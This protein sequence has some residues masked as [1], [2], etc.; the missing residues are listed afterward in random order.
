MRSGKTIFFF[1]CLFS[2][3]ITLSAQDVA[4]SDSLPAPKRNVPARAWA[5]GVSSAALYTGS[6]VMLNEYWYKGYPRRSFHTMNDFG[7]WL[8]MDKFGHV[9]SAYTFARFSREIWRWSELP[10][11]QQVLI[12]AFSGLAFQSVIEFLDAHS[13]EWGWSWGDMGANALGAGIMAA[14][15]LAWNEQRIQLKFSSTPIHYRD[16]VL[17]ARAT[18]IFGTAFAER[19]LKDYNAQTYWLSLNLRSVLRD[20]RLPRWLNIAAGYGVQGLYDARSNVWND[21]AGS[22]MDFTRI[23]RTRQ[24]YLSPDVDLTRIPTRKKGVK[25]MLQVLNMIKIPAP[26]L[27]INGAGQLKVHGLMF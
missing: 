23:R 4:P 7:E 9:Y 12:G 16:P 24:F 14:Q 27:E 8:Q 15:E 3:C 26:T 2:A 1:S 25:V 18:E 20:S 17:Q 13:V 19:V 5:L 22:H 6:L 21:A 10:R 11:R